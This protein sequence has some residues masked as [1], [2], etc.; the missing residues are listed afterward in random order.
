M[1]LY[2]ND[3]YYHLKN[4][5][6]NC[7]FLVKNAKELFESYLQNI[8]KNNNWERYKIEN[9]TSLITK[10]S[11]PNWQGVNYVENSGIFFLTSKN[12][13]EGELLLKNKGAVKDGNDSFL[14]W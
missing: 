3:F 14:F 4:K 2:L 5:L 9:L 6:I 8:F 12:V 1:Q 10:G 7:L 13:G 11:S